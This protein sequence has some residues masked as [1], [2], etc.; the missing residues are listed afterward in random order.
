VVDLPP[1]SVYY[2]GAVTAT[3]EM[4]LRV[5]LERERDMKFAL[6]RQPALTSL[7]L[8]ERTREIG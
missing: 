4:R 2:F 8:V 1:R 3:R 5:T 6:T 7:P